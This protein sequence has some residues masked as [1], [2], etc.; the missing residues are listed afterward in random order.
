[1]L[2]GCPASLP[3]AC[4]EVLIR[5]Y[6][7]LKALVLALHAKTHGKLFSS[8]KT[9]WFERAL[10]FFPWSQENPLGNCRNHGP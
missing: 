1:M 6:M 5:S 3:R 10:Q 9:L 7:I 8:P 2:L 4:K